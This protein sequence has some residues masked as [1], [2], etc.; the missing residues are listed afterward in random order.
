MVG[1]SCAI[2][3]SPTPLVC[4]LWIARKRRVR[5]DTVFLVGVGRPRK[6]S[7]WSVEQTGRKGVNPEGECRAKSSESR[8][9]ALSKGG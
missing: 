8:F 5:N 9:L 1:G 4:A 7:V 6:G 2:D 3:S